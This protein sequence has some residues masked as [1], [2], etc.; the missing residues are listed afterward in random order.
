MSSKT[1]GT[2]EKKRHVIENG[3]DNQEIRLCFS[4]YSFM[5]VR[6]ESIYVLGV[7]TYFEILRSLDHAGSI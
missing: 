3:K 1:L 4:R 7:N 6:K 5:Q 2:T